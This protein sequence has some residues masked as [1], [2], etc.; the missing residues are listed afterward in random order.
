MIADTCW[1]IDLEK[2]RPEALAYLC[3][4]PSDTFV[5][6]EIVRAEPYAGGRDTGRIVALVGA[7]NLFPID[8]NTAKVW[9]ETARHL[10]TTGDIVGANDLWIAAVAL[11]NHV[12]VLTR[13]TFDFSRIRDLQVVAY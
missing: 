3:A 4:N 11:S 2:R 9:G 7:S 6:T 1:F 10:R 12:P 13:N 5:L 8:D